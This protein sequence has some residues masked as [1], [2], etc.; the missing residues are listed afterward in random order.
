MRKLAAGVAVGVAGLCVMGAPMATAKAP[1]AA[2]GTIVVVGPEFLLPTYPT[3][4]VYADVKSVGPCLA[5]RTLR[6]A[7]V[8]A[9]GSREELLKT[10]QTAEKGNVFP[11]LPR[12][13]KQGPVTVMVT[14]DQKRRVVK[15]QVYRCRPVTGQD[16]FTA[17]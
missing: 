8:Y 14:A 11:A 7:Y 6:F 5:K 15:G 10:V 3:V 12:P 17:E 13:S 9:D 16:S 2:G 4:L 1:K